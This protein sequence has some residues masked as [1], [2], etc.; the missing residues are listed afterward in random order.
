MQ[1]IQLM[2]SAMLT[3]SP[4]D[5]LALSGVLSVLQ[6]KRDHLHELVRFLRL[7]SRYGGSLDILGFII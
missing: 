3:H 7:I 1:A 4:H 5:S 6:G 2:S